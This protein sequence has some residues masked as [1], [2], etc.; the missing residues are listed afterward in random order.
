VENLSIYIAWYDGMFSTYY[1]VGG[2][3]YPFLK[4]LI[5][6]Y[7]NKNYLILELINSRGVS[8]ETN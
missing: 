5:D 6:I 1:S 3:I 8:Y 4:I 7:E 2:E